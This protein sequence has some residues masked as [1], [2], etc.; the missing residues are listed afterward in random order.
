MRGARLLPLL[1]DAY[2]SSPALSAWLSPSKTSDGVLYGLK[3]LQCGWCSVAAAKSLQ[4]T[5]ARQQQQQHGRRSPPRRAPST[6]EAVGTI[7]PVT[8]HSSRVPESPAHLT[9]LLSQA[10]D[11]REL[12]QVVG[13]NATAL[14]AIHVRA[15][16]SATGRLWPS[17]AAPAGADNST[18]ATPGR[19]QLRRLLDA[20]AGPLQRSLRLCSARQLAHA[21]S[22]YA[23]AG[24]PMPQ[25]LLDAV[26]SHVA[27]DDVLRDERSPGDLVY[28][29]VAAAL[30]GSRHAGLF[31]ALSCALLPSA[32]QL[33]AKEVSSMLWALATARQASVAAHGPLLAELA[34]RAGVLLEG[35]S[36]AASPDCSSSSSSRSSR[37][38]TGGG[39]SSDSDSITPVRLGTMC[40]ALGMLRQP[41]PRALAAA[42]ALATEPPLLYEIPLLQAAHLLQ[43]WA[44][45]AGLL[46][47]QQGGSSSSS[48]SSSS[49]N[50]SCSSSS[51]EAPGAAVATRVTQLADA[52]LLVAGA[53]LR[54]LD[55]AKPLT[56]ARILFALAKLQ[57]LR[58]AAAV[59]ADQSLLPS[60]TSAAGEEVASSL[61]QAPMQL[62]QSYCDSLTALLRAQ[63]S[64]RCSRHGNVLSQASWALAHACEQ[65]LA[66][67]QAAA[68][69]L[70]TAEGIAAESAGGRLRV[71]ELADLA[72]AWQQ[73]HGLQQGSSVNGSTN[74]SSSS[75]TLTSSSSSS[76]L[77]SSSSRS[78]KPTVPHPLAGP[79]AAAAVRA[80]SSALSDAV[81]P[82]LHAPGAPPLALGSASKLLGALAQLH[83][84]QLPPALARL[85]GARWAAA[86][87][88]T[89]PE[90]HQ[91]LGAIRAAAEAISVQPHLAGDALPDEALH[92]LLDTAARR[93]HV[94]DN[95]QRTVLARNAR[96]LAGALMAADRPRLAASAANVAADVASAA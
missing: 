84:A 75:S 33:A 34:E 40:W 72:A 96:A 14:T 95:G 13:T 64:T 71:L 21:L 62:F 3:Y 80:V 94:L 1:A 8:R 90:N 53:G 63:Q 4:Q 70:V 38:G 69:L 12:L 36:V 60:S 42:V 16:L 39:G 77:T 30:A 17:T 91:L 5:H 26:E 2:L 23:A 82:A 66:G 58:A 31:A 10:A 47:A 28:L 15:A 9:M 37:R 79:D 46:M 18:L 51:R 54:R 57:Q 67:P 87:M 49:S 6:L 48:S 24:P 73:L 92:E 25:G 56:L 85:L 35:A 78:D 93:A 61:P 20:L 76:S 68:L 81:Q 55:E 22:V 19:Q 11:P 29:A 45:G 65:G 86:L 41:A 44:S 52:S 59:E 43:G 7:E 27:C 50:S 83:G 74:I 32:P 88:S 89:R